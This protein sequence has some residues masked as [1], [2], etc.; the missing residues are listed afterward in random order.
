MKAKEIIEALTPFIDDERDVMLWASGVGI[1][2]A[3]PV[4]SVEGENLKM[5]DLY[6]VSGFRQGEKSS[7]KVFN[8][9]DHRLHSSRS[10]V[11]N[12]NDYR[13]SQCGMPSKPG[14]CEL[15]RLRAVSGPG[16]QSRHYAIIGGILIMCA[17]V[18]FA[19]LMFAAN[20]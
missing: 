20:I 19:G 13:C 7:M 1:R 6:P 3:V 12:L 14:I 5:A 8:F 10:Q 17:L 9:E 15:C 11:V 16:S 18:L 4:T 2:V